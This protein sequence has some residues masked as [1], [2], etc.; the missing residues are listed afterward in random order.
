MG[1]F[2]GILICSDIDGTIF[3]DSFIE[4]PFIS[5]AKA[6]KYFTENGGR[7]TFITGRY[8]FFLRDM[9]L[10][11]LINAPAGI[12]N[13]AAVYDYGADKLLYARHIEHTCEELADAAKDFRG[14]LIRITYPL[15]TEENTVQFIS[16]ALPAQLYGKKPLKC[17]YVFDSEQSALEF[18][19]ELL[20]N[21]RFNDCYISRSW[22]V[23]VELT[24]ALATKGHAAKYIKEF[25]G[26]QTL[27]TIGDYENDIP[28]LK[29]ADIGAAVGSAPDSVKSSADIIVKPCCD[30][31]VFDLIELLDKK[32]NKYGVYTI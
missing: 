13:G 19:K 22:N 24:S 15:D 4:E 7:F 8:K 10:Y 5:N 17:I 18:K 26:A 29:L 25:T 28:M 20:N 21:S 9:P 6:V 12:F 23:S 1:K 2:D 14:H 11:P 16:G 27:V 3:K 32:A 31:A 30:G